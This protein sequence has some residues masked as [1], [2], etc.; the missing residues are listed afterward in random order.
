MDTSVIVV[1]AGPAGLMLAG[2]LRLAGVDVIVLERLSRP[3]GESRGLGFSARTM[4]VFDQRGLLPEFGDV[5]VSVL[6]HFG[7]TPVDFSVLDGAHYGVK[8]IAQARTEAVLGSWAVGL[9]ADLRRG[10]EVL[11]FADRGGHVEVEV[12]DAGGARSSLNAGY[13]VG[14][15]GGRST[16]RKAGGFD[17][18]GTAP[19]REMFLAD[20][21]GGDIVPRPIG[22]S[23]PGGMIMSAPL[24]DGVDRIVVCERG[25]PPRRRG[26]PPDFSEV[27]GAWQR[28]SGQ[29]ISRATPVWISAFGDPARQVTE[30]RR[31][32]V[33]LAGD[34]AHVH[35]P[36]GGQGMNTSIQ[37]S[38]NLGWKLAACVKGTGSPALLDSYH[39]E[40]HP[41]GVRLLMNVQ[42]QGLLFLSGDEMQPL[43]EVMTE[44]IGY[45][46]VARHLAGM[47]SGLEIRYDVGD[48]DHP[49]LGR[50]MPP[51][52]M[53][54][55]TGR[56]RPAE[57]LRSGRG[58][59]LDLADG[60]GLR[61]LTDGWR[62]RVDLVAVHVPRAAAGSVLSG[63]RAV[64]IRPDG[65]VAWTD[66]GTESSLPAALERWFGADSGWPH[67]RSAHLQPSTTHETYDTYERTSP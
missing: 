23:V 39:D 59:L 41:V 65:H 3:S 53:V 34:A 60:G 20:I 35:L 15:D 28:L 44:L 56:T 7:G 24:G 67:V 58:V 33:L 32:R 40:R 16:V 10:H 25:R 36:A 61:R 2:E 66:P 31:G 8:G 21:R 18:P 4:E 46:V 19:T 47:V 27:A 13:L 14:C 6:G 38:V 57:L 5:E 62:D 54:R 9:G 1:G 50:R 51:L 26:G 37:D 22:Q 29:D 63:T 55:D 64:L 42:A 11:G 43:R 48:G 12:R 52:E 45:D 17:F 49:L 30:Y